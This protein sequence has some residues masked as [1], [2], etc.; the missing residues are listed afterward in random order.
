[1]KL[2]KSEFD[3]ERDLLRSELL[4]WVP[5][6]VDSTPARAFIR[7]EA[8]IDGTEVVEWMH[9]SAADAAVFDGMCEEYNRLG[10]QLLSGS[11]DG[12]IPGVRVGDLRNVSVRGSTVVGRGYGEVS[13]PQGVFRV[14]RG[15][16]STF[17]MK[18]LLAWGA[19]PWAGYVQYSLTLLQWRGL[20]RAPVSRRARFAGSSGFVAPNFISVATR[21]PAP[22]STMRIGLTSNKPQTVA[23]R[24]RGTKGA[25]QDVLFEDSFDI[26]AGESEAI[27]NVFGFPFAP[28]FTLELQPKDGTSTILD[29]LDAFP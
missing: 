16:K 21:I 6:S 18:D 15:G 7:T 25:F 13:T 17:C 11:G 10:S 1:M 29:Y 20:A 8:P 22:M 4:P 14:P 28:A 3:L 9:Y 19:L 27:Y 26:E 24:G 12:Y 2:K 5:I 23:I